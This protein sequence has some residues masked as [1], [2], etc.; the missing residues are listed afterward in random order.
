[1]YAL[2]LCQQQSIQKKGRAYR[3]V[4]SLSSRAFVDTAQTGT[5]P[6]AT[7]I[8]VR[9]YSRQPSRC[10]HGTHVPSVQRCMGGPFAVTTL[11]LLHAVR[12]SG[13]VP[14]QGARSEVAQLHSA[15]P[16]RVLLQCVIGTTVCMILR[17]SL[18][19]PCDKSAQ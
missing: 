3:L 19:S 17:F 4:R 13:L 11:L 7:S 18:C 8:T 9:H 1:M 16:S 15:K 14:V 6:S 5:A 12:R 10:A 2:L